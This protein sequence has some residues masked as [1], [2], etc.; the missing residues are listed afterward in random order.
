L[1]FLSG[2]KA[3]PMLFQEFAIQHIKPIA[4]DIYLLRFTSGPIAVQSRP[5]Q[6]VMVRPPK[7]LEPLLPRPFSIHRV[8]GDQ[9]ELLFKVVGQGT[10]QLA[11][12]NKG[13]LLEVRGP[14]GQGFNFNINQ[15]PI[16]VA[17]GMGVAPLLFLAETWRHSQK[18]NPK[19]SFKLFIGARNKAELLFLKEFEQAGAEVF[20]ATE[21]GSYGRKGL[22]TQLLAMTIKK[23]SPNPTLFVCG[24]NP[25]LKMVR[26]WAVQK[27]I[28]CQLS[29]ET[30]MACGLGACLGC[31]VARKEGSGF[32]YVKVCQEGPVFEA[33]EVF[34]D[35]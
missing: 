33:R 32:S 4:A 23:P 1:K 9:V 2:F 22:V 26:N 16:L 6:F 15:N 5:G 21:D 8:Q 25:M 35:E 13:D 30:H 17:G 34:W 10:R 24:P 18:K 20:A 29:L 12:L 27:K 7:F 28:P 3:L 19:W 14:L 31:A 11:D